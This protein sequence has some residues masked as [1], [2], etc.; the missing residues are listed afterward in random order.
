MG[1]DQLVNKLITLAIEDEKKDKAQMPSFFKFE[2]RAKDLIPNCKANAIHHREREKFHTANLEKAEAE[3]KEKGIT[4]EA[5][6][7]KTGFAFEG[8]VM[9]GNMQYAATSNLSQMPKFT[10]RI[11]QTMLASV[12]RSKTK[13]L[14]HRGK[15]EQFEKYAR[16]FSCA[17]DLLVELTVDDCHYF[18][19]EN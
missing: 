15:A 14:E 1:F 5:I 11:D 8:S 9:S 6:D 10:P 7:P 19:L 4:I 3:L 18:R 16:A 17:P 13:M 12:E 2:R